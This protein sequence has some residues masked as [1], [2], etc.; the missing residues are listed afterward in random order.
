[1]GKGKKTTAAERNAKREEA[2]A[3]KREADAAKRT[4]KKAKTDEEDARLAAK[5][6]E[7]AQHGSRIHIVPLPRRFDA[8]HYP[9][10]DTEKVYTSLAELAKDMVPTPRPSK[11]AVREMQM[12]L[13]HLVGTPTKAFNGDI[14]LLYDHQMGSASARDALF[15]AA[16]HRYKAETGGTLSREAWE[17]N[18][19]V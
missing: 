1:M 14:K 2:N 3:R 9:R 13:E 16:A 17:A 11:A 19:D 7:I 10:L 8:L 12:R 18:P 4:A 15:A 6:Q 5:E